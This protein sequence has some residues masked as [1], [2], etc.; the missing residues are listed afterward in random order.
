MAHRLLLQDTGLLTGLGNTIANLPG[1]IS[2]LLAEF[3]V[4]KTG[5]WLP[6]FVSS[7]VFEV[8]ACGFFC[9]SCKLEPARATLEGSRPR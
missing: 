4:R 3:I 1:V 6:F 7:A 8:L 9:S 2:P 5:S